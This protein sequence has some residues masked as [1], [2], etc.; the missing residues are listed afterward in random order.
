[1]KLITDTTMI[2]GGTD[3]GRYENALQIFVRM[4]FVGCDVRCPFVG[5]MR[6]WQIAMTLCLLMR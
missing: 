3:L 2:E 6:L 5:V 1:M 4:L